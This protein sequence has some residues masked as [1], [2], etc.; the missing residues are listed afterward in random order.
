MTTL[1]DSA[2]ARVTREQYCALVDRGVLTEDDRV[3]LLEG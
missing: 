3:E 1:A 2:P